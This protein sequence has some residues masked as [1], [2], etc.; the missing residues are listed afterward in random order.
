[1]KPG[2]TVVERID[3]SKLMNFD[4]PGTY[5]IMVG[6]KEDSGGPAVQEIKYQPFVRSNPITVTL[7][8]DTR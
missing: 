7:T 4:T 6:Y 8:A 2:G 3:L 1:V 5:T